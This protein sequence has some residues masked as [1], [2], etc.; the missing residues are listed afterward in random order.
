M[1]RIEGSIERAPFGG[2]S[3]YYSHDGGH[4]VS[5]PRLA[6]LASA[7]RADVD[8][9]AL[10]RWIAGV[11]EPGSQTIFAGVNRLL[12]CER[13]TVTQ[14]GIEA[15][16]VVPSP[17]PT[18]SGSLDDLARMLRERIKL[19][20][21]GALAGSQNAAIMVGGLDSCGLAAIALS[22]D[23]PIMLLTLT[24]RGTDP[25]EP[26]VAELARMYNRPLLKLSIDEGGAL[27][28][29]LLVVDGM[30]FPVPPY[31]EVTSARL[32]RESGADRVLTGFLGDDVLGGHPSMLGTCVL[33]R[34][35]L[36]AI[37]QALRLQTPDGGSVRYRLV[38][39]LIR[40]NLR[41]VLPKGMRARRRRQHLARRLSWAKPP[42]LN[43]LEAGGAEQESRYRVPRS[44]EEAFRSF[45]TMASL[46]DMRDLH[47]LLEPLRGLPRFAPVIDL[48]LIRFACALPY[49]VL[50]CDNLHRGL[51]RRA[52]RG[53]MPE[54]VRTRLTKANMDEHMFEVIKR[55]LDAPRWRRRFSVPHLAK[56]GW[57]DP[58]MLRARLEN[59][60]NSEDLIATWPFLAADAFLEEQS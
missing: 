10:A 14:T 26:Y 19:A 38:E 2:E 47:A 35:P 39:F 28:E 3:T 49:E 31:T 7:V 37:H 57:V 46:A 58:V 6:Q 11:E 12:P 5:S 59:L 33:P 17:G 40:P 44:G 32:L 54:R 21:K 43:L 15:K 29:S 24:N 42:F 60:S 34:H 56:L 9:G 51:Y 23:A 45:A 8:L 20:V 18:P 36:R 25:D 50:N 48:E 13:L 27:L 41:E 55:E 1:R 22:N 4:W 52:L 53:L 16:L 30:P